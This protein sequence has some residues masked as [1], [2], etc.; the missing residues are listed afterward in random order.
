MYIFS[1]HE[2]YIHISHTRLPH[3]LRSYTPPHANV[4]ESCHSCMSHVICAWVMSFVHESCRSCMRFV[5]EI[6]DVYESCL[7]RVWCRR[8]HKHTRTHVHAHTPIRAHT[9]MSHVHD[10]SITQCRA[11][12]TTHMWHRY[13][14]VA[15]I[16]ACK[17]APHTYVT[18]ILCSECPMR[19]LRVFQK[20]Y[21]SHM[22]F[23]SNMCHIWMSYENIVRFSKGTCV[24]YVW[25]ACFDTYT[26]DSYWGVKRFLRDVCHAC[27]VGG[28]ANREVGGWGRD[29]F[30]RNFMKPTP[31]RKWYLT[32]GR[33]FH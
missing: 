11:E 21:V 1:T 26:W 14:R 28:T 22:F 31:R 13:M 32:T 4:H 25:V 7:I 17:H 29:P 5:H 20:E 2:R 15:Y 9:H 30:S 19:I 27:L 33:R 10:S 8:T 6:V 3:T 16:H 12:V 23:K 24:T 18:D